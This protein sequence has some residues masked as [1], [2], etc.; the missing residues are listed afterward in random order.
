MTECR[1]KKAI[2]R[3]AALGNTYCVVPSSGGDLFSGRENGGKEFESEGDV[4]VLAGEQDSIDP[5]T[6]VGDT[7][8]LFTFT[9]RKK[10]ET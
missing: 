3:T 5:V 6:P 1:G 10:K 9:T 7:M 4:L 8:A 2:N